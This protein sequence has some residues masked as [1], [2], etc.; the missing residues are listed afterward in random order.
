MTGP[1]ERLTDELRDRALEHVLR[2]REE[3]DRDGYARHVEACAVCRAEIDGLER[4]A[5]ELALASPPA[6]PPGHLRDRLFA[7]IR[8]ERPAGGPAR[9]LA[10]TQVWKE[11]TATAAASELN[12][13]DDAAF[14]PTAIAGITV[15]R[16]SVDRAADRATMLVRMAPGTSYP[17][18]RHGGPEEC[19]V[20]SG[21]LHH[22]DRVMRAGDYELTTA[23]TRHDRQWTDD[24]CL[25]LI[26]SSLSDE[27]IG[28]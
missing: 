24:G 6:E 26:R 15:R 7:R 22:D 9:T 13:A 5:A 18:H 25:L 8:A 16:L 28:A 4:A 27:L 12:R 2:D 17:P 19:F 10:P 23:G 1:H 14:E 11:W 3:R 20:L 21:D